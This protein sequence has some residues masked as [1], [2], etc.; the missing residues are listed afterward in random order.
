MPKEE[1]NTKNFSKMRSIR[2]YRNKKGKAVE[3]AKNGKTEKN[4]G[5]ESEKGKSV[6]QYIAKEIIKM[7]NSRTGKRKNSITGWGKERQ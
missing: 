6:V 4:R 3:D 7:E 1:E 5:R 2:L